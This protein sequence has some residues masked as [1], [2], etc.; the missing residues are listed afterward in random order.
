MTRG[1]FDEV[2]MP[3]FYIPIESV[4]WGCQIDHHGV[5]MHCTSKGWCHTLGRLSWQVIA[6]SFTQ[7]CSFLQLEI[8]QLRGWLIP[9]CSLSRI[10][11]KHLAHNPS[12]A[13]SST[14]IQGQAD[15]SIGATNSI[16]ILFQSEERSS[17]EMSAAKMWEMR[18]FRLR[19]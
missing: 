9:I 11:R 17:S 13:S 15:S 1:F 8:A 6:C 16:G 4:L 14:W 10:A 12:Q 5:Q 2:L 19:D 3:S 7:Q 18:N